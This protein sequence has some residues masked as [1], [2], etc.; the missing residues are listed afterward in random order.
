MQRV[1]RK[2]SCDSKTAPGRNRKAL[3]PEEEEDSIDRVKEEV[4]QVV[5]AWPHPEDLDIKHVGNPGERVP[6]TLIPR[7][8]G[9][10][11]IVPSQTGGDMRIVNNVEA[12]IEFDEIIVQDRQE[13]GQCCPGQERG[14]EAGAPSLAFGLH[15]GGNF[16]GG[17]S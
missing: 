7:A 14:K 13:N 5:P 2:E 6:I 3:K 9:P 11:E 15:R 16:Q 4:D 10:A 1:E 8:Q 12:I 17:G